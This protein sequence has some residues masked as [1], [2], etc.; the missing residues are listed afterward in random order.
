MLIQ[1]IDS[2]FKCTGGNGLQERFIIAFIKIKN[3]IFSTDTCNRSVKFNLLHKH[4]SAGHFKS[5]GSFNAL[6]IQGINGFSKRVKVPT[7]IAEE[8]TAA[9]RLINIIGVGQL[10][11][12]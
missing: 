7:P 12:R 8:L 5:N 3:R 11:K 6:I 2:S 10:A 1:D 4:L 9:C